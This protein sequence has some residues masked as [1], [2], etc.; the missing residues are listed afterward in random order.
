MSYTLDQIKEA[1]A[2]SCPD[3]FSPDTLARFG[4]TAVTA[5][6]NHLILTNEPADKPA[7]F[8]VYCFDGTTIVFAFQAASVPDAK[9][10]ILLTL[11][12]TDMRNAP[13]SRSDAAVLQRILAAHGYGRNPSARPGENDIPTVK[14]KRNPKKRKFNWRTRWSSRAKMERYMAKIRRLATKAR[15]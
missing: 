10:R 14:I 12:D 5:Y 2:D 8:P 15:R 1:L 9:E 4:T 6:Q 11:E 7:A 3:F 13:I